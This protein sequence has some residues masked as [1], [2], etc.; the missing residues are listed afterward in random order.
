M[1]LS[2]DQSE[3]NIKNFL[4]SKKRY[5][6]CK[7]QSHYYL[8]ITSYNTDCIKAALV[9]TGQLCEVSCYTSFL[10]IILVSC[11]LFFLILCPFSGLYFLPVFCPVAYLDCLTHCLFHAL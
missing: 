8:F 2:K 7:N 3:D 10:N 6:L 5:N 9:I 1:V 4:I 11:V